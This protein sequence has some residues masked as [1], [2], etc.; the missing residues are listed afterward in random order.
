MEIR[1]SLHQQYQN[2]QRKPNNQNQSKCKVE[3]K[4]KWRKNTTLLV[5]YRMIS[6]INQQSLSVKRRVIKVRSF[7]GG[8][9][10]YMY[11]YI[12]PLLKK[13]LIM[14]SYILVPTTYQMS[15]LNYMSYVPSCLTCLHA[16]RAFVPYVP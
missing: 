4:N 12:K 9:I 8:T 2:V 11:D 5:G 15:L 6:G 13:L 10:D 7:S 1:T 3:D 16:L 14:S